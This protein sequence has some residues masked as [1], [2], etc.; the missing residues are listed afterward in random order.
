MTYVNDDTRRLASA[1]YTRYLQASARWARR[2]SDLDPRSL[3]EPQ[4]RKRQLLRVSLPLWAPDD[5]AAAKELTLR[6]ASMQALYAQGRHRPASHSEPL[7]LQALERILAESRT[8]EELQ[9]AWL[10]WH[11]I[12][13]PM[14]PEFERYVELANAGARDGGFSDLGALWRSRY[15]MDPREVEALVDRL[16]DQVAPLYRLLHAFVR[17]RLSEHYGEDVVASKGPIPAHLLGNMWA[18]SWEHILPLVDGGEREASAADLSAAL[19][20]KGLTPEEMVRTGE[21]FFVSL[22]LEPLPASFWERSMFV[23][24]RD[25]EVVCHASAWDV[26]GDE[27]LRLK[28][29]IEIDD[30]S[31]RVIHHELGHNYYQRAYRAQPYFFREGAHDGF[32]EAVGDTVALSITPEYLRRIGLANGSDDAEADRLVL[33]RRALEKIAFLPFGLLIDRWRWRVFAGEI[34]ADAYN[35]TWNEHR[36]RYQGVRAPVLRTEEDFDPGAKYHVPANVPYLRYFFAHILQFQFHRGLLRSIGWD[37]PLHRGS[38]YGEKEAGRRLAAM[39]E[40][41]ASR[42]WPETLERVCGEREMDATALRE[43]FRPLEEWMRER[44]GAGAVGW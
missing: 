35:R 9:D 42:P 31:F 11:R 4:K 34:R 43:Y 26:D 22:G 25:R 12:A 30:E 37:G 14:R 36:E 1:A 28:M 38:V 18:Q 32:H 27:D 39:L 3:S 10:G 29:C 33:L 21:R 24:P 16:W 40:V 23:R 13:R 5:A 15:D 17:L 41:G 20:A 6:I 19:R 8:P 44:V 7:D 2:V